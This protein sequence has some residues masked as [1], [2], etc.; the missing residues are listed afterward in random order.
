M[1]PRLLGG[2]LPVAHSIRRRTL[3]FLMSDTL[4]ETGSNIH[5]CILINIIFQVTNRLKGTS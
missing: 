1:I 5:N 3:F 4:F 2:D